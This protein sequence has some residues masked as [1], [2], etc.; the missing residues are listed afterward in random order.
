VLVSKID[1][2]EDPEQVLIEL[3]YHIK[4]KPPPT[5]EEAQECEFLNNLNF[6]VGSKFEFGAYTSRVV[7]NLAISTCF[8]AFRIGDFDEL[9]K[10]KTDKNN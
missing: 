10:L 5:V 8:S 9:G 1:Q 6:K 2:Y 3:P 4:S 7:K